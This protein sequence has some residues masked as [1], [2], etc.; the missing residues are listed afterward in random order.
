MA[1]RPAGKASHEDYIYL[2]CEFCYG[3]YVSTD[4]WIHRTNCPLINCPNDKQKN[5]K[6]KANS[7]L[8]L[9]VAKCDSDGLKS[10]LANMNCDEVSKIVKSDTLIP[11]FIKINIKYDN[12]KNLILGNIYR[13]PK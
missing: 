8:L 10:V 13:P 12:L 11:Q 6:A 2:P 3:Y 5:R 4:L 9:P 1:Y 7:R